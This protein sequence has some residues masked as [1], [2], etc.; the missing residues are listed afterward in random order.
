MDTRKCNKNFIK[1]LLE[2]NYY[3]SEKIKVHYSEVNGE[4]NI[5]NKKV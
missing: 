2:P 4:W 1:Y 3:N 5:E